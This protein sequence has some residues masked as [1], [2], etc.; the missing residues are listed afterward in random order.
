MVE[1]C[2]AYVKGVY[3]YVPCSSVPHHTCQY[4]GLEGGLA[5]LRDPSS[6]E[7]SRMEARH[8]SNW[9]ELT[10]VVRAP[11]FLFCR[12]RKTCSSLYRQHFSS[13]VHTQAGRDVVSRASESGSHHVFLGRE[14]LTD[15]SEINLKGTFLNVLA[16]FSVC[17]K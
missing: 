7:K 16:D 14:H 9:R 15:L 10:A 5:S 3:L 2:Q 6:R 13:G 17:I 11:F 1:G 4:M 8:S 12:T